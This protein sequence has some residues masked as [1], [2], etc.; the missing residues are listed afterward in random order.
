MDNAGDASRDFIFVEDI[1]KG[2]VAC[3]L[4]GDAGDVYNIASGRDTKILELAQKIIQI[5]QSS[6]KLELMPKRPWDTSGKR[7]GSTEKSKTK[8]D[9]EATIGIDEGLKTTIEW[10]K[11]N[12]EMIER[13]MFKHK[14]FMGS[15]E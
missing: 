3:A 7:F 10:T 4:K 14:A 6:S 8:L 13:T 5:T 15:Y 1:C 9:F 12:L 2:L 11:S